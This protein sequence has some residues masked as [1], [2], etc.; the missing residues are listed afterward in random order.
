MIPING[1]IHGV[2]LGD[3]N[4]RVSIDKSIKGEA[5]LPIPNGVD[6]VTLEQAVGTHVAWPQNF[7]IMN[8]EKV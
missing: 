6:M 1:P 2:P 7:V 4:V 5:L 8:N 3:G